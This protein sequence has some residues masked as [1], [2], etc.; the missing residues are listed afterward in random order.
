MALLML[1]G[2]A[3]FSA[4]VGMGYNRIR[5]YIFKDFHSLDVVFD[6]GGRV[7]LSLTAVTVTS[8]LLWPAD[9]LQSPTMASK[10]GISGSLYYT[11]AIVLSVLVFAV[12]CIQLKTRA[13]GAKTFPQIAYARFGKP[14]HVLFCLVALF[15]N[16]VITANLILAGKTAA[17]VLTKDSNTEFILL[18]LAVLFGS[19]CLIGGLGTTFYISYFNTAIIFITASYF[20]LN[21]TFLPSPEVEDVTSLKSLYQTMHCLKG[22]EGNYQESYL[23]FRSTSG[24]IFGIVTLFMTIGIVF[25][26]QANWQSRIAAKPRE[27]MLGF[28]IGAFLWF[29]IPTPISFVSSMTYKT[30]SY[31]NGTNLL[32]DE[33]IDSGCITPFVVQTLLGKEGCFV[34]LT[35][36][37]MT[38]MSTGSGEVMSISSVLVYDLFKTH[39]KPFRRGIKPTDCVLCGKSLIPIAINGEKESQCICQPATNCRDCDN[40]IKR[41]HESNDEPGFQYKCPTHG[42]YRHYEDQLLEYK[43]WC[44]IWII[45]CI[46]PFGLLVVESGMNLNWTFMASQVFIAPFIVPLYFTVGWARATS[47]GLIAGGI[48]GLICSVTGMLVYGSTYDGGLSDFYTNTAQDFSLLTGLVAGVVV[49]TLVSVVVSLCM[50]KEDIQVVMNEEQESNISIVMHNAKLNARDNLKSISG[51]IEV[52]WLKT[53][54]IDN[55]L[56]PY[57][58]IYKEELSEV[59][60][61]RI[62]TVYH[63]ETIFK[64]TRLVSYIGI[65]FSFV[66]FLFVIPIVSLSQEVLS[67]SQLTIWVSACQ[68]W[69]LGATFFVVVIPPVQEGMQIWRQYKANKVIIGEKKSEF[70]TTITVSTEDVQGKIETFIS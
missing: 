20:I 44:M 10:V 30:M 9:F 3:G 12:L 39:I 70:D 4:M 29:A 26:D 2:F 60:A 36:L 55:P 62:L 63:M 50:K 8:Q 43:S 27:G 48:S 45:I 19:Y 38:L 67:E 17:D 52:E 25:C 15:T 33:A 14:A 22:P 7:S 57:R 53:M 59:N 47:K 28:L 61:G 5:H 56:K 51:D 49:S 24:L 41:R 34:F 16:L 54:S 64:K 69:C 6:A 13:P 65:A 18:I 11:L 68:Y 37:T 40:D 58:E 42:K 23:T 46:I 32:S 1:L 66:V 35:L 21:V 31:R